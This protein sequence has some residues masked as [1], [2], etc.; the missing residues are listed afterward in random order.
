MAFL[1]LLLAAVLLAWF[2]FSG[3]PYVDGAMSRWS[4][5]DSQVVVY[6]AWIGSAIVA[7]ILWRRGG[8]RL[9]E[10]AA[11]YLAVAAAVVM[12]QAVAAVSQDLN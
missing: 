11:L 1:L 12:L 4:R 2:V 9:S 6:A 3:D 8:R 7:P 5:R 10:P